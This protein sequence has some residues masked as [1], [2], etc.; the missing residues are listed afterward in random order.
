[1]LA[2]ALGVAA[3]AIVPVAQAA[4]SG[5]EREQHKFVA[6]AVAIG[7][8]LVAGGMIY[9]YEQSQDADVVENGVHVANRA[10]H[11][12]IAGWGQIVDH[13]RKAHDKGK[14]FVKRSGDTLKGTLRHFKMKFG[15]KRLKDRFGKA[16]KQ[17]AVSFGVTYLTTGNWKGAAY[18]CAGGALL[19]YL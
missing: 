11:H 3:L 1:M 4:P 18:S 7:G 12:R 17:C 2:V 10:V 13:A 6:V 8:A 5:K 14:A 15:V 9:A 19:V 16:L